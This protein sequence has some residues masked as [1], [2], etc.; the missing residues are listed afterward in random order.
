MPVNPHL[1]AMP[2]TPNHRTTRVKDDDQIALENAASFEEV[3]SYPKA[4]EWYAEVKPTGGSLDRYASSCRVAILLALT[5]ADEAL[6][7]GHLAVKRMQAP[8]LELLA[9]VARALNAHRGSPHALAFCRHWLQ[10][11]KISRLEGSWVTAAG[12]AA[13]CGQYERSLRYLVRS[14]RRCSGTPYSDVLFDSDFAPLWHHL[15]NEALTA[16]EATSLSDPVWQAGRSLLMQMNGDVNFEGV[17]HVPPSLRAILHL[18][19]RSMT[20]QPHR[21][22]PP[23]QLTAFSSWCQAVRAASLESLDIGL[24]K[25]LAFKPSTSGQCA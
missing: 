10:C 16:K 6:E 21:Q 15:E 13:Q 20:W 22:T 12:Y 9:E 11:P 25:A 19:T 4:L 23:S 2:A 24:R 14:L 7:V 3:R 8:D 1:T 18:D 5:R 17:R